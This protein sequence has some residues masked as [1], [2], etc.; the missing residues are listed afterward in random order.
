MC[1]AERTSLEVVASFE[2]YRSSILANLAK[3]QAVA[4]EE[5]ERKVAQ[6]LETA[7]C[8]VGVL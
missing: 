7:S 6:V 1:Q 2:T 4:E 5:A 8:G 3:R